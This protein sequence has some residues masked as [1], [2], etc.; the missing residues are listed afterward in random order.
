MSIFLLLNRALRVLV[1]GLGILGVWMVWERRERARP[2]MDLYVVWEQAGYR[3]PP[4]ISSSPAVVTKV[5]TENVLQVRDTNG[6]IWNI[7]LAGLGG[8]LVDLEDPRMRRFA[9]E[10]RTNLAERLVGQPVTLALTDAQ[11]N[12][13][14]MGFVYVG[15]NSESLAIDLVSRGRLRWL[16]ESTRMLPLREQALLKGA[17]RRARGEKVG[18]WRLLAA[19]P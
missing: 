11:P 12:R 2:W 3:S 19:N 17:D 1:V 14:G 16:E 10:T 6:V 4:G 5:L 13:T 8:V 9:S 18:L 7:G 15:T